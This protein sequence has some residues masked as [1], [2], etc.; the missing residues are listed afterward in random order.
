METPSQITSAMYLKK[1][2]QNEFKHEEE[3][4]VSVSLPSFLCTSLAIQSSPVYIYVVFDN[5][6][7]KTESYLTV[8]HLTERHTTPH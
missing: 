4:K 3:R 1:L 7:S 5:Y 6:T 2:V 8:P